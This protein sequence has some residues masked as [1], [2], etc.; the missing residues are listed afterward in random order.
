MSEYYSK[1]FPA[2]FCDDAGKSAISVALDNGLYL[3]VNLMVLY[4]VDNQDSYVYARLFRD[5]L[6]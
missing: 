1:E 3:S 2:I 4:I 6:V 5:N